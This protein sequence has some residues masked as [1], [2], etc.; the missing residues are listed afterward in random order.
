MV[1]K[2]FTIGQEQ[3]HNGEN[4]QYLGVTLDHNL[5]F[6]KLANIIF[7]LA[8]H[9]FYLLTKIRNL[10]TKHMA[11]SIYK[12][13]ILPYFDY[14]DIFYMDTH[15]RA[16]DKLQKLHNRALR[17]CLRSEPMASQDSLH[18][19]AGL[20]LLENRRRAHLRNCMYKRKGNHIYIYYKGAREWNGLDVNTRNTPTYILQGR[21]GVEWPRC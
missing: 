12:T 15:V 11:L 4:Y 20:P 18:R 8:S 21:K 14:G 2:T 17:I 9:K 16:T 5:N 10:L 1:T 3:I 7:S 6:A 19:Q 13:K